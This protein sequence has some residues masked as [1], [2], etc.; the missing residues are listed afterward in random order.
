MIRR[1]PRSTLFPYTTLSRSGEA[2]LQA[3]AGRAGP[4]DSRDLAR[5]LHAHAAALPA[6][7]VC[8]LRRADPGGLDEARESDPEPAVLGTLRA[9][10]L[11]E[12]LVV[13]QRQHA[14]ERGLV[15]PRVVDEARRRLVRELVG[16]D[17]VAA[18]HVGGIQ[19]ALAGG[20]LPPPLAGG[21]GPRP[22]RAPGPRPRPRGWGDRGPLRG[23]GPEA[24]RAR[25]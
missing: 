23:G 8:G 12:A 15:L 5:R 21:R 6:D 25:G 4:R 22:S 10:E 19:A 14:V 16:A 7:D 3:V 13:D 9:L 18:A 11:A 20:P 17:Q 1:P 24:V 2:R